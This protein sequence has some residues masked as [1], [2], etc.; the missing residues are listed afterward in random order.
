MEIDLAGRQ[1]PLHRLRITADRSGH[2]RGFQRCRLA[3]AKRRISGLLGEHPTQLEQA[4]AAEL[5]SGIA[6]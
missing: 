3:F 4:H 5:A 6:A 2:A 1:A